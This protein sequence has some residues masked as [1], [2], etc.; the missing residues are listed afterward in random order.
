M[1]GVQGMRQREADRR[2][3]ELRARG[4]SH[5]KIA[6]SLGIGRKR[7]S[8][9]LKRL[10]LTRSRADV[11]AESARRA[12]QLVHAVDVQGVKARDAAAQL[13]MGVSRAHDTLRA[14][15]VRIYLPR[16]D[17]RAELV[18]AISRGWTDDDI[19]D[20]FEVT[21]G[22]VGRWRAILLG[23]SRTR[24]QRLRRSRRTRA[25][26]NLKGAAEARRTRSLRQAQ[27]KTQTQTQEGGRDE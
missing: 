21:I 8:G 14:H 1:R 5:T 25:M 10:G 12:V 20:G 11:I 16:G 18:D 22:T 13:G 24:E 3:A 6:R 9:A 26:T 7:V 4:M 17:E 23:K 19:A 27:A 15:G 2:I